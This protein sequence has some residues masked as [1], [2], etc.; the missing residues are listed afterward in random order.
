MVSSNRL[1]NKWI[2]GNDLKRDTRVDFLPWG[3]G[4]PNGNG[5]DSI[6]QFCG[7][8]LPK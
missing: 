7:R 8:N 5:T 3:Y 4:Q 6:N 2:D 1:Q